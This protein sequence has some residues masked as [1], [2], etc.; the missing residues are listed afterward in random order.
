MNWTMELS[1]LVSG[2]RKDS[3]MAKDSKFGRMDLNMR[4]TGK[5]IWLTEKVD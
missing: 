3:D 1:M 2:P 5:M 4:A